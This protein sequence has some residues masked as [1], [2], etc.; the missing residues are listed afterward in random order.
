VRFRWDKASA[1]L[2]QGWD[3]GLTG[4]LSWLACE[5]HCFLMCVSDL[6]ATGQSSKVERVQL[7]GLA[8]RI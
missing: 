3:I 8:D 1:P 7:W 6:V 2:S 4:T 5:K